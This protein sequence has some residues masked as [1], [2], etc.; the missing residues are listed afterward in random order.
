[1]DTPVKVNEQHQVIIT[2]MNHLGQGFCR[3]DNF[4]VFVNGAITGDKVNI[5]IVAAKKSYAVADIIEIIEP[6]QNR[7]DPICKNAEICGGCQLL[8]MNYNEQLRQKRIRVETDLKRIGGFENIMVNDTLGMQE[9]TRYRNKAQYPVTKSKGKAKIGFYKRGSHEI[10]DTDKCMIQ[11]EINDEVVAIIREY[12]EKYDVPAYNQR[13]HSGVIRH[14]LTKV[15]FRTGDLM[16]V[17]IT[18]GDNLPYQKE[19]V[20]ML[21]KIPNL[22][23]VVQNINNKR[24]N[25]ILGEKCVTLYGDD[26]ITDY[27]GDLEFKI[28]PLSFFQVN[29]IQ[30][31]VLY[32]KALEYAQ[33]KG[34]ETVF[35]LYCGIGTISLFLA[36]S[37]KKVYGI[38]IVKEAI[39]DA[40]ENAK[41]N[42]IDNAEFYAGTAEELF[43]KLYKEGIRADVVMLDPPRKGCEESVL[44]T[45][46][47][48][49]PQKV[50]YVSC[51]PATLARDLKYLAE[52]GYDVKEV[53][54]VDMFG[55]SMHVEC[56]TVLYRQDS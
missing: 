49:Q 53:Q 54:P 18:K 21:K 28:S 15:S 42:N 33:L 17:I 4:A 25:V 14:I 36:K 16:V 29:P 1:M 51:N 11:H 7:V 41:R 35:D 12:I 23:S 34:D 46:V 24:S 55:H 48:M 31:E 9:P 37:A 27:I 3:I 20:D 56:V 10:V 39:I 50:V 44:E 8:S 32:G 40:K 30:T 38:E 47:S 6:S 5:K 22:K 26:K 19:L 43:P 2:D 52:N 13:K 45:I